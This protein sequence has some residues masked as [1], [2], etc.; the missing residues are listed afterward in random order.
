[1]T[2]FENLT[3]TPLAASHDRAGFCCGDA[4]LDRYL[5]RQ[6]SQDVRRRISRV[7]VATTPAEPK[8]A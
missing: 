3:V 1:M 8:S 4:A 2:A 6:A 7:F 5:Q